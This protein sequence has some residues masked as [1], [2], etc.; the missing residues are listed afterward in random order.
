MEL[1]KG[2]H[3]RGFGD[4][5]DPFYAGEGVILS[6]EARDTLLRNLARRSHLLLLA[7]FVFTV[8]AWLT[9]KVLKS[10]SILKTDDYGKIERR[11][12]VLLRNLALID[13]TSLRLAVKSWRIKF[14][15]S[16]GFSNTNLMKMGY[17]NGY[18]AKICVQGDLQKTNRIHMLRHW[19]YRHSEC[20]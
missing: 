9:V 15:H 7:L 12:K 2:S 14:F 6:D 1:L 19:V 10:P 20:S 3:T 5:A 17:L 4:V 8:G 18:K 16:P 13:T 11:L